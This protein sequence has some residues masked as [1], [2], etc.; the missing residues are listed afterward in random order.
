MELLEKQNR[1]SVD[2]IKYQR[3]MKRL[4]EEKEFYSKLFSYLLFVSLMAGLNYYTNQ[5]SNMW[6]LWIAFV[7]GIGLGF[8]AIKIFGLSPF[9]GKD[10]EARKINEFMRE[11]EENQ[12]RWK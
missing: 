3:A 4:A 9:L 1:S 12:K 7:W 10:W 2:D 11:E 6:F 8:R 5:W